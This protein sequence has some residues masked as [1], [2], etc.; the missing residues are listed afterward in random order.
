VALS[1]LPQNILR[2]NELTGMIRDMLHQYESHT[3][4]ETPVICMAAQE[5]GHT[6]RFSPPFS[7]KLKG[8]IE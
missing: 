3:E 2:E 6:A 8:Q 1:V 7:T 4:M 5:Y